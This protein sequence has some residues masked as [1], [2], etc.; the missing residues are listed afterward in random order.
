MM[1]SPI[2]FFTYKSDVSPD[3]CLHVKKHLLDF[4]ADVLSDWLHDTSHG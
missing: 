2:M 4:V 1:N 3:F